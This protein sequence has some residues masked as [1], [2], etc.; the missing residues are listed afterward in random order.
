MFGEPDLND[1]YDAGDR[2]PQTCRNCGDD[3]TFIEGDT[4]QD[5]EWQTCENCVED[6]ESFK[7][8]REM[9][10]GTWHCSDDELLEAVIDAA[11]RIGVHTYRH[12]GKVYFYRD[13]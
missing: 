3:F 5:C 12:E 2:I 10:A 6:L 11:E 13:E 7:E 9:A 4:S 8:G 1:L